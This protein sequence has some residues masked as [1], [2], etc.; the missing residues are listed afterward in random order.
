MAAAENPSGMKDDKFNTSIT[1]L[2][3]AHRLPP[4]YPAAGHRRAG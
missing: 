4:I 2:F 3:G 1:A